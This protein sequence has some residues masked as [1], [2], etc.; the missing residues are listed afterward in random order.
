MEQQ[1]STLF[2]KLIPIIVQATKVFKEEKFK[3]PQRLNNKVFKTQLWEKEAWRSSN[4]QQRCQS[5]RTFSIFATFP[6]LDTFLNFT[7][8]KN[9][10]GSGLDR[11]AT[12]TVPKKWQTSLFAQLLNTLLENVNFNLICP[13]FVIQKP[14][15]K[16]TRNGVHLPKKDVS[17]YSWVRMV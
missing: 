16:F 6:I 7:S 12:G 8:I 13:I 5:F 17:N 3:W 4:L 15:S 2:D 11:L 1:K 14:P 9:I 10:I